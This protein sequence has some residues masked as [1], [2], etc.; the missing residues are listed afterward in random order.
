MIKIKLKK[1]KNKKNEW[2]VY[3]N[4]TPLLGFEKFSNLKEHF[5]ESLKIDRYKHVE[6]INE[7]KFIEN[8]VFI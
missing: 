1:G 3:E 8:I 5:K 7:D 6:V 4:D 2:W